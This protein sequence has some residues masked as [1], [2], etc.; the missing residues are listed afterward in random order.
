M[1]PESGDKLMGGNGP[2][3]SFIGLFEA[4]LVQKDVHQLILHPLE[5]KEACHNEE[6]S[7]RVLGQ[8]GAGV[9]E[10]CSWRPTS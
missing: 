8:L 10:C 3:D 2:D 4:V 6:R 1:P 9:A 5:H 7:I